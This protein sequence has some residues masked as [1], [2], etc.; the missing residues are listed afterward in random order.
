MTPEFP[1][2]NSF[3]TLLKFAIA[4]EQ[5]SAQ[6]ARTA[7]EH[8]TCASWQD[9]LSSCAKKHDK[10]GKQLERL[11]RERLNE[12][13]L[14]KISGMDRSNYVPELNL[15]GDA[16]QI[17]EIVAAAED[18][19][20]RFYDDAAKIAAH[21]LTGTEKTFQKLAGGNIELGTILRA[22]VS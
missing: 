17:V 9:D 12:V 10:R 18:K 14:E 6:L 13:V 7:S 15:S 21:V 19:A 11:R 22:K 20:A 4:L 8:E 1:E 16:K 3:G 2:L 5:A